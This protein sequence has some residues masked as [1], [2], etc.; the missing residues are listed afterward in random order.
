MQ[1]FYKNSVPNQHFTARFKKPPL[2]VD[3][4]NDLGSDDHTKGADHEPD[5][6]EIT[7]K[8]DSRTVSDNSDRGGNANRPTRRKTVGVVA[9]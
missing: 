1:K 5:D 3:A 6:I 2:Y 7:D 4:I 9:T 8:V